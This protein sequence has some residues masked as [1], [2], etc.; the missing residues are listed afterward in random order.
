MLVYTISYY[1]ENEKGYPWS[2]SRTV[3]VYDPTLSISMAGDYHVVLENSWRY[4]TIG[5]ETG[6]YDFA[7]WV[8]AYGY[9]SSVSMTFT[10]LCPG[11]YR[12]SDLIAGW[13]DQIRGYGANYPSYNFKMDALVMLSSDGTVS[14]LSSD[15]GYSSWGNHVSAFSDGSYDPATGI[16]KYYL[17]FS[18]CSLYL[19]MTLQNEAISVEEETPRCP[20]CGGTGCQ[21]DC[22]SSSEESEESTE[23]EE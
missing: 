13:Y 9:V 11:I 4:G 14:L 6:W 18:D 3:F 7:T 20:Y 2:T 10:E 1:A 15:F 17:E 8:P 23:T 21:G 12:C 5:G 19:D 16:M 22:N